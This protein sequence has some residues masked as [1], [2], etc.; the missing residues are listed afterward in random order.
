MDSCFVAVKG[1]ANLFSLHQINESN[2]KTMPFTHWKLLSPSEFQT[3]LGP[4]KKLKPAF[5]LSVAFLYRCLWSAWI[6]RVE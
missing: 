2:I 6:G 5:V 1:P 4:V 3:S